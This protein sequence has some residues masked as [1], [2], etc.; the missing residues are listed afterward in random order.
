MNNIKYYT[1]NEINEHN[2]ENDIWI[3]IK[4]KVYDLTNFIHKHPGQANTLMNYAGK[5]ATIPFTVFHPQY[6]SKYMLN[7]F[8]I[9]EV[10]DYD[11]TELTSD[12]LSLYDEFYNIGLFNTNLTNYFYVLLFLISLLGTSV[13]FSFYDNLYIKLFGAGLLGIYWQQLALLGHDIGHN[14]FTLNR[15]FNYLFGL[16]CINPTLGISLGFWKYTHNI[17][18]LVTNSIENDPDIQHLPFIAVDNREFSTYKST[19]YNKIFKIDKFTKFLVSNQTYISYP[20][21][22]IFGRIALYVNS[23]INILT[24][25]K[26]HY[27]K[28]DMLGMTIY[29]FLFSY[30]LYLTCNN[31]KQIILYILVSH[32]TAGILNIQIILSHFSMH[33]YNNNVESSDEWIKTQINSSLN[34]DN[35]LYM[36]WF[37]GGLNLQ[38]EHHLFPRLSK[39][40]LRIAQ[41]YI[42]NFCKKHNL[43]YNSMSFLDANIKTIKHLNKIAFDMKKI[44]I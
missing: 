20:L 18:H 3:S 29:T 41:K 14:A 7:K 35:N 21:I 19:F 33:A 26:I 36:D 16:I 22:L 42:I 5:D 12:F 2:K 43:K 6:V 13:Y 11:E 9:G 4:G 34:I 40:N 25:N 17:H 28:L 15:K 30:L 27:R 8:Y 39:Y 37:H 31:I 32:I 44:K 24:N 10:N 23:I 38:I 1:I